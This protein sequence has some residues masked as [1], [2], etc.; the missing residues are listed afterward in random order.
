MLNVCY[1]RKGRF[2]WGGR[3]SMSRMR[4]YSEGLWSWP[5]ARR[6]AGRCRPDL[7]RR[8]LRGRITHRANSPTNAPAAAMAS[9]VGALRL[10]G[11]ASI[12][13]SCYDPFSQM[14]TGCYIAKRKLHAAAVSAAWSQVFRLATAR[15]KPGEQSRLLLAEE[16]P[17]KND[18]ESEE[19]GE[20][21][22]GGNSD[23]SLVSSEIVMSIVSGQVVTPCLRRCKFFVT[24]KIHSCA[25]LFPR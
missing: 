12:V 19:S 20:S 7:S 1:V 14:L 16:N 9:I 3:C 5:T 25:F 21:S 18:P 4:G 2:S 23:H 22:S 10:N 8:N 15:R 24:P 13:P 17:G 6:P 11:F